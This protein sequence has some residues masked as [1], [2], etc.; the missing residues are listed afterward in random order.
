MLG[1][2]FL[3]DCTALINEREIVELKRAL[4]PEMMHGQQPE[5]GAYGGDRMNDFTDIVEKKV[6]ELQTVLPMLLMALLFDDYLCAERYPLRIIVCG[7]H[8]GRAVEILNSDRLLTG[9][10]L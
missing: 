5:R 8:Y 3:Y 6:R 2:G 10:T 4:P 1:V 7:S 9:R